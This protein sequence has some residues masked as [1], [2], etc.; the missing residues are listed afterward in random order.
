MKVI[1]G[2]TAA[3]ALVLI[4]AALTQQPAQSISIPPTYPPG[5]EP[6]ALPE[7]YRDTLI[8]FATIERSDAMSRNLYISLEALEAFKN[9][10]PLPD[11]TRIVIEAFYAELDENGDPVRD[12][13]GRLIQYLLDP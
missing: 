13:N 11:Y 1:A 4:I 12:E 2:L 6:M 5:R 7:N 8:H 10:E 3:L 9:G